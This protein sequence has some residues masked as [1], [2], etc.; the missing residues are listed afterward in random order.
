M[1]V[2]ELEKVGRAWVVALATMWGW[3]MDGKGFSI[4]NPK[5]SS[6]SLANTG[7]PSLA[8]MLLSHYCS[9]CE[10]MSHGLHIVAKGYKATNYQ[11]LCFLT[12]V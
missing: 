12:M 7:I 5:L 4:T 2:D 3:C 10:S 11:K 9:S 1:S 8:S 6:L